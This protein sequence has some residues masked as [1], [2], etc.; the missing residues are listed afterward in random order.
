MT[1]IELK[2]MV[3]KIVADATEKLSHDVY[4]KNEVHAVLNE[5]SAK[6]FDIEV[7]DE[8]EGKFAMEQITDTL[9]AV[10]KDLDYDQYTSISLTH[11]NHI[12]IEFDDR[13]LRS[14]V[15]HE[16]KNEIGR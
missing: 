8:D 15:L 11:D 7:D 3:M 9:E 12:E 14:D 4:S 16:L 5:V 10:L 1:T 6:I 13:G 2:V